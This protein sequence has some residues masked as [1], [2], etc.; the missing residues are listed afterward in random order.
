MKKIMLMSIAFMLMLVACNKETAEK[1][2]ETV[3]VTLAELN[4][5]LYEYTGGNVEV[6]GLCDHVCSH[7]GKKMFIA[8]DNPDDKLQIFAAEGIS[9]FPK[10]I[11]GSKIRVIGPLELEKIDLATVAEMEA[12]IA[13]AEQGTAEHSCEFESNMKKIDGLKDRI[14]KSPKGYLT[15][16]TMTTADFKK[17]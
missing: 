11:E 2:P 13:A 6:E 14:S 3:K 16:Y 7:S 15:K 10:E 4:T 5:G 8:G 17:M 12:E 9:G 1:A